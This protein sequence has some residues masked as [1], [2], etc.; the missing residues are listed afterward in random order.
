M[1]EK[2]LNFKT[3]DAQ[4][5]AALDTFVKASTGKLSSLA[6]KLPGWA[7][8]DTVYGAIVT[9]VSQ[10][11]AGEMTLDEAYSRIDADIA[12]KVRNWLSKATTCG[13]LSNVACRLLGNFERGRA[14]AIP[15]QNESD[16]QW[17]KYRARPASAEPARALATYAW[18][19]FGGYVLGEPVV[20][21][22]RNARPYA[23]R[24]TRS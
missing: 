5:K 21:R 11:A 7:W 15:R 23:W 6:R 1:L 4:A 3:D 2:G 13:R 17:Q 18:C 19:Q 20:P 9:R 22:T 12:S 8:S 24:P 14:Y 16:R 10:A